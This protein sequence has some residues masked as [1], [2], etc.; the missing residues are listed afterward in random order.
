MLTELTHH[1]IHFTSGINIYMVTRSNAYMYAFPE[2]Y[3]HLKEPESELK[4]FP[5]DSCF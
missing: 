4:C 2:T 5:R 1:D 3:L